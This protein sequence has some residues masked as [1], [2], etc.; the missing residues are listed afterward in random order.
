MRSARLNVLPKDW[1]VE[2]GVLQGDVHGYRAGGVVFR[3]Y[4]M[5]CVV[6]GSVCCIKL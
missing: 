3:S 1:C 5:V 4:P 2:Q 6:R